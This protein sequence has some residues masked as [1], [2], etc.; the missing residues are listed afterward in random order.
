MHYVN[1]PPQHAQ[2]S[3]A[4]IH[5]DVEK[6]TMEAWFDSYQPDMRG[7]WSIGP[8]VSDWLDQE[9]CRCFRFAN[10]LPGIGVRILPCQTGMQV[11]FLGC[12]VVPEILYGVSGVVVCGEVAS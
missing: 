9:M 10:G 12:C 2:L 7:S 4:K 1:H 11:N 8:C 6:S 5:R 3:L